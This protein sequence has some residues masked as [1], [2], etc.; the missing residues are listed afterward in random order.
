MWHRG[1]LAEAVEGLVASKDLDLLSHFSTASNMHGSFVSALTHSIAIPSH[2]AVAN[3]NSTN[4]LW[5]D[6]V[7]AR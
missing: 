4:I 2:R 6:L 7:T 1:C 3:P 5:P